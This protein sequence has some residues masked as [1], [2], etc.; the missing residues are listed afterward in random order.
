MT[1][2]I[3][4]TTSTGS[5]DA[6]LKVEKYVDDVLISTTPMPYQTYSGNWLEFDGL[7]KVGYNTVT[8]LYWTCQIIDNVFE[9]TTGENISWQY[10][11]VQ[12]LTLYED[13][14]KLLSVAVSVSGGY[15]GGANIS[16][17]TENTQVFTAHSSDTWNRVYDN[18]SA[19]VSTSQGTLNIVINE[20]GATEAG[21]TKLLEIVLS[22]G[23]DTQTLSVSPNGNNNSYG[24][25]F[26][27]TILLDGYVPGLFLIE[28]QGDYYTIQNDVL[29]NIG[30]TLNAQL[31]TDYGLDSVPDWSE[32][33]SLTDPSILC[34]SADESVS[35][36]AK[37][38]GLASTPQT[39]YSEAI[40][41]SDS[42]ITGIDSITATYEGTPLFAVSLDGT[43]WKMWDDTNERWVTLSTSISGMS[44][45][46]L[47]DISAS[48][49]S[50]FLQSA[51]EFY[52]RFTLSLA[53]DTL[54]SVVVTFTH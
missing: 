6:A 35:I 45:T 15:N 43:T 10:S 54:E 13:N 30:S 12:N 53:T 26:S 20:P 23:A 50:A 7:F 2:Y 44:G 16:I 18:T 14:G 11:Q 27:Q 25:S 24:Y 17:S 33:S 29:T 31:F 4:A 1:K 40:D 46:V 3:I 9:H 41:L 32:Y 47:N 42:T 5:G 28:S 51:T 52:L 34:W 38:S 48:I 8:S 22:L 21:K 19:S 49:W 39:I 36:T 37:T